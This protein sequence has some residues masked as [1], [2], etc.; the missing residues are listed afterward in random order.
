LRLKLLTADEIAESTG[1]IN[2]FHRTVEEV[3]VMTAVKDA[4]E[5]KNS[6]N[7]NDNHMSGIN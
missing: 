4:E 7:E 6:S 1:A 5:E 3:D 2:D